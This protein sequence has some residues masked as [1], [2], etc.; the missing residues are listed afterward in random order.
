LGGGG[1]VVRCV[2]PDNW[3]NSPGFTLK[4]VSS[5]EIS[6][7]DG[8]LKGLEISPNGVLFVFKEG[9]YSFCENPGS[10]A[11][12]WRERR[13]L[14]SGGSFSEACQAKNVLGFSSEEV[15]IFWHPKAN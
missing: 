1:K 5:E 13:T 8:S 3:Q 7:F 11:P 4:G 12:V 15:T 2:L 10:P 9:A 6:K 14:S